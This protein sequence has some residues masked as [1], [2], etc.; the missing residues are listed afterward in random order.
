VTNM[1]LSITTKL[2]IVILG[3]SALVILAMGG[4]MS[5]SLRHSFNAYSARQDSQRAQAMTATLAD[6]YDDKKSW[7]FIRNNP[8]LWRD[9]VRP[10]LG[11]RELTPEQI[12]RELTQKKNNHNKDDLDDFDNRN[13]EGQN[14]TPNNSSQR[15][16]TVQRRPS[17]WSL[18]DESGIVIAGNPDVPPTALRYPIQ[19]QGNTVGWIAVSPR[20]RRITLGEQNFLAEQRRS[21]VYIMIAATFLAILAALLLARLFLAPVRRLADATQQLIA[22]HYETRAQVQQ[23]DELGQLAKDFNHLAAT[24]QRNETMRREFVADISHELRTPLAILKGELEAIQD[25]IR[26]PDASAIISLQSE[27]QALSQLVD[28][29]YQISL[30]DV[31]GLHYNMSSINLNECI[32]RVADLFQERLATKRLSWTLSLPESAIILRADERRLAQLFKNLLENTLRYTDANG[33]V[34]LHVTTNQHNILISLQDSAP[35]VSDEELP[36]I[37]ERLYRVESSRNRATGGAGLGLPLC[38]TIVQAHGGQIHAQHSPLGGVQIN[39]ILPLN[40]ADAV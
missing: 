9:I 31:G 10:D 4:A 12:K 37:F 25:G 11:R 14:R 2:F 39:I 8:H 40:G 33:Q 22:G 30:S 27:T 20:Q 3:I 7:D 26:K 24:L 15:Q 36:K 18:L 34:Q 16:P 17:H 1:R 21:S 6:F 28:D 32:S 19:V 23:Q 5:W 13:I 35:G 38:Q 29:L